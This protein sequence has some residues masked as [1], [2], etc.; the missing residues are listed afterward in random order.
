MSDGIWMETPKSSLAKGGRSKD[1]HLVS[2]T[3]RRT[4]NATE[5]KT[6]HCLMSG[7]N[8][9]RGVMKGDGLSGW[10]VLQLKDVTEGIF[11]SRMESYHDYNSNVRTRG[12]TTVNNRTE[13]D[14]GRQRRELKNEKLP[15]TW[16]FELAVNGVLQYSWNS[17]E[18]RSHCYYLAYNNDICVLWDDESRANSSNKKKEDVEI[19]M[20]LRGEGGRTSLI[21]MTHVYYA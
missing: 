20:R 2:A 18:Y 12:W 21:A 5:K 10:L 14:G 19:A 15:E 9:A 16:Q 6:N 17:T 8:D 4:R 3:V 13:E 7:H 11:M 1:T